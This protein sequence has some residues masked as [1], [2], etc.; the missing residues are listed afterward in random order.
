VVPVEVKSGSTG[1]MQSLNL[2]IEEKK[3]LKKLLRITLENFSQ[4]GKIKVIL[5]YAISNLFR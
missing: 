5:L 1:K 2:C 4:Y 3:S